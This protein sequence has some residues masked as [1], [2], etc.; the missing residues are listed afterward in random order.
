M[1][2]E[3]KDFRKYQNHFQHTFEVYMNTH[4]NSGECHLYIPVYM[5]T[6]VADT[7]NQDVVGS[8]EEELSYRDGILTRYVKLASDQQLVTI[9]TGNDQ[10][11]SSAVTAIPF[12]ILHHS[13]PDQSVIEYST[14]NHQEKILY[15]YYLVIKSESFAITPDFGFKYLCIPFYDTQVLPSKKDEEEK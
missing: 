14:I 4:P 3:L 13:V 11:S 6:S 2:K 10:N 7:L 5:S 8:F 9:P 12:L 15:S 1:E